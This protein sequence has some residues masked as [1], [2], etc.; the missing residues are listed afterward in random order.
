LRKE[1]LL[2]FTFS[3]ASS[4]AIIMRKLLKK[5]LLEVL[6]DNFLKQAQNNAIFHQIDKNGP[7]GI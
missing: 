2:N 4:V 3:V 1:L 6:F 5:T 7:G